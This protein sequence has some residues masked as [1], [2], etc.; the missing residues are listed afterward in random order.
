MD[1]LD[2]LENQSI[3]IIREAKYQ[4]KN[5]SLLWS[6]GKDSTTLLWLCRKAFFGKIPFPVMHIDTTFK[7]PEM[8]AFR[9]HWAKEWGLNMVIETNKD[10][11]EKGVSYA[12]HDAFT[13]CHELK[14]VA[15]KAAI[16]KRLTE[17]IELRRKIG[18]G[19][20][21]ADFENKFTQK[22]FSELYT[23]FTCGINIPVTNLRI[24]STT[25]P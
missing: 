14:T 1:Y 17:S 13:C 4:F 7:F 8:Y 23:C 10:A 25:T 3:Y 2:E 6:I 9:D 20:L 5:L 24:I 12:T 11:I 21:I 18:K 19:I 15:L 22:T 16:K